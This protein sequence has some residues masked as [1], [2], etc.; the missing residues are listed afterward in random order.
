MNLLP[1][2]LEKFNWAQE[3]F[4]RLRG[5]VDAFL[6]PNS[7]RVMTEENA[8][9][10]EYR[11]YVEFSEPLPSSRWGLIFGDGVHCLRSALDHCVYTIGVNESGADP[12]PDERVLA[13]PITEDSTR[14]NS[15]KWHVRSLSGAAQA[16]IEGLQP[17]GH[18]EEFALR[19]LGGLEEFD[20]ADKHRSDRVV[21]AIPVLQDS[22]FSGLIPGQQCI[23]DQRL[24][25]VR[26]DT[27][28]VT[29]E[30]DRSTP[31]VKVRHNLSFEIGIPH[32]RGNGKETTLIVWPCVDTMTKAVMNV[33]TSLASFY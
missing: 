32:I 11:F 4:G 15:A 19:D 5:E 2:A 7:Y 23:I 1:S 17:H 28:F 30:L 22:D 13:F 6:R 18:P 21:A 8:D 25:Y 27:P 14:W 20:N 10:T 29:L 31:N 9:A 3:H 26:D 16:V 12:P 33:L 24:G